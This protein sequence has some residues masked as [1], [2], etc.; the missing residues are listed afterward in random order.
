M[1]RGVDVSIEVGQL[2]KYVPSH[3]GDKVLLMH[4]TA[5]STWEWISSNIVRPSTLKHT[6][7]LSNK[8]TPLD[9]LR[10]QPLPGNVFP[11]GYLVY[12]SRFVSERTSLDGERPLLGECISRSHI[13]GIRLKI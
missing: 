12:S 2:G 3:Q 8:E 7:V 11:K 6:R 4:L 1:S 5:P 10:L 9:D 13:F